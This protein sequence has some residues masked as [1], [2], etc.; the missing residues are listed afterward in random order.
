MLKCRRFPLHAHGCDILACQHPRARLPQQGKTYINITST[1]SLFR[2]LYCLPCVCMRV[3][4]LYVCTYLLRGLRWVLLA[5]SLGHVCLAD[6]LRQG[7]HLFTALQRCQEPCAHGAFHTCECEYTLGWCLVWPVTKQV[8][9]LCA[10]YFLAP[11]TYKAA[12][13]RGPNSG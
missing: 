10:A 4:I 12:L 7:Q 8:C 2:S 11:A 13:G 3:C 1:T 9:L 6:V 5:L